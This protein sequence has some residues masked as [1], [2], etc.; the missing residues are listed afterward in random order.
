MAAKRKNLSYFKILKPKFVSEDS[1][2][3]TYLKRKFCCF[4]VLTGL[5]KEYV[6]Q[7]WRPKMQFPGSTYHLKTNLL[8]HF[9]TFYDY[10]IGS[11]SLNNGLKHMF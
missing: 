4:F 11:T 1:E 2:L 6:S 8:V 3:L 9:F 7:I 10:I 5:T